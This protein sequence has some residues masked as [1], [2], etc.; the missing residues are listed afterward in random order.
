MNN[1]EQIP[2]DDYAKLDAYLCEQE[3]QAPWGRQLIHMT[4]WFYVKKAILLGYKIVDESAF[5]YAANECAD[6]PAYGGLAAMKAS[7]FWMQKRWCETDAGY[8]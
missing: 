4:R 6:S 2:E 7:Y 3:R 5:E 1:S 8:F